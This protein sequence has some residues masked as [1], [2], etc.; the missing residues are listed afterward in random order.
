MMLNTTNK[1]MN[2][3]ELYNYVQ[4][5][6]EQILWCTVTVYYYTIVV[7]QTKITITNVKLAYTQTM[8]RTCRNFCGF[9]G[10]LLTNEN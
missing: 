8:Y 1:Q 9:R 3:C 5:T 7:V 6:G 2:K 10:V 4:P